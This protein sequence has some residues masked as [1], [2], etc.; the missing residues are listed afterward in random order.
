MIYDPDEIAIKF[1][2]NILN[3]WEFVTLE[4]LI[5]NDGIFC[6]GD[7][8][9]S[10]DQDPNGNVRL[11]QLADIGDG[12]YKDK[13][14][15]FLTDY[16]AV[17]INCTFLE[18]GDLLIARLGDPLGKACIFPGD[19]KESVTAVDVCIIRSQIPHKW[20]MY[21]IN[22]PLFRKAITSLQSGTTRKRISRK[23]LAKI[24]FPLPPEPEQHR[25]VA[26]IE[27]LF[28]KLDAGVKELENAQK[29][30]KRYRQSVLKS[31]VEGRLTAD[32]RKAHSNNIGWKSVLLKDYVT[33][34]NSGATPK[35]GKSSYKSNGIPL[36]RSLNIRFEKFKYD[37][38]AFIDDEQ[39]NKLNNAIVK[40]N[41][42]L[43]NITGASIGRVNIAPLDMDGARVNQH[44]CIIRLIDELKAQY[45]YL[46]IASP[47]I[48]HKILLEN[49][50][51][52]RQALTKT[53]I[54]NFEIPLPPLEEQTQ[55]V[56]VIDRIFSIVDESEQVI[57]AELQRAQS[58]RQSILKQAF[59][60]KLVPQDPNEEP[61]SEL[62]ERIKNGKTN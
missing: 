11:I 15:R 16:K 29:Q 7:W 22:S 45:L 58:L 49:Y 53:M 17:E 61:A 62:L 55:I 34:V 33:K 39:A 44:V 14:S 10:K 5:T 51:A 42:V 43:L 8:I 54:L 19:N 40:K 46:V 9:E 1:E 36:I 47:I 13:S 37:N 21:S 2:D 20:L 26:K 57:K 27:E 30:L 25:I 28:S 31:A 6:D 48:Q 41:D 12:D 3:G 56:S 38:L 52:T 32:W 23:N 35:G 4:D 18:S 59:E 24:K 60:G 50:G